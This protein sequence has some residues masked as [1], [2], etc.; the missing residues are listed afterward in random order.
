MRTIL[1]AALLSFIIA[2]PVPSG[3]ETHGA[4]LNKANAGFF[5]NINRDLALVGGA[6]LGLVAASGAVN[7]INAGM[8]MTGGAPV[9]EAL[10]AGAGLGV[11]LVLLGVTLGAVFGQDLIY[12]N[13]PWLGG[14]GAGGGGGEHAERPKSKH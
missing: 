14:E 9:F 6:A 12:R 7:L 10:E 2:F 4:P 5:S 1:A 11:P 13:I 3:A 8:L